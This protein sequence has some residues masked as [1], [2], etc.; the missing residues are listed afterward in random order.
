[1]TEPRKMS[2][3][4][5]VRGGSKRIKNKNTRPFS[6]SSLLEIKL[7]QVN[8][9]KGIADVYVSSDDD[10][11]LAIAKKHN[12]IPL[13]RDPYY[14]SDDVPMSEVYVHLAET[15]DCDDVLYLHV[16]SPLL[17]D[18]TL[19]KCIFVYKYLGEE[20]DSLATVHRVQEY[21]WMDNKPLN[22]DPENHPRSQDLP[23]VFALNFA[24]NIIPRELMIER[25]NL[26]G[27]SVFPFHLNEVESTDIDS[28]IDFLKAEFLYELFKPGENNEQCSN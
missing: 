7:A 23:D 19:Q 4:I 18:G 16:T 22:Y 28:K 9:M 12:A 2:A 27:N 24:V 14:A 8:K 11:M 17:T 20:N 3:L 13:K 1:M 10:E 21:L 26:V 6:D 15:I 25:K 5:A